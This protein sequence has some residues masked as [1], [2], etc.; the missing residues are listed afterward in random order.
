MPNQPT[1]QLPRFP[2]DEKWLSKRQEEIIEP[3]LP[4][5]D[6]H[7]HLWDRDARYL[8]PELL[9]DIG[10]GH[11]VRATVF[12]QCASMYRADGPPELRPIGE[13]EFVNGAAAMSA[14]GIYGPARI[15]AGI[16]GYADLRLGAKVEAV[17]EA[18]LRAGGGRFRGIRNSTVWDADESITTVSLKP[19]PR[20]MYDP[21]WR[22][23][24]ARLAPL[25]LSFDGWL[26]YTQLGEVTD[27]ARAFPDTT[28]IVDHVG[29]V[30]G[31]AA[32]A[33]RRDEIFA[34]WRTGI[35]ELARCPNVYMKLGGLGMRTNGFDFHERDLPPASQDLATAWRP[36]VETCI[37]AFGV[38]RSMFESNF[39][40]DKGSCSY[41]ILWNAL[42]RLASGYSAAE[43]KAL[44]HDTAA[45]VYRL[46]AP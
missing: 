24:F 45:K 29:G 5:I 17:L 28:I 22:E 3:D 14:S 44:F 32:Y 43:K 11:N 15:C 1:P 46:A 37:A 6:P 31:I 12:L 33:G 10:S 7:H 2:I 41:A 27:L 42:K 39:P 35:A 20:L 4:I 38:E 9:A 18:H 40:V 36:Y 34:Q 23:G 13:T 19:P 25:K 16:V 26:Y 8:F 30:L 21:A